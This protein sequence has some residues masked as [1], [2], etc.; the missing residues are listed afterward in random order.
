MSG[1]YLS[2]QTISSGRLGFV[3]QQPDL[4]HRVQLPDLRYK[5]PSS[6]VGGRDH[7]VY[8]RVHYARLG[9]A[10]AERILVCAG[11][12]MAWGMATL[13]SSRW[14]KEFDAWV[15]VAYQ[16]LIEA[17]FCSSQV[18]AGATA[19]CMGFVSDRQGALCSGL[20]DPDELDC[21]IR[22]VVLCGAIAIPIK[23]TCI[24]SSFPCLV[25]YPDGLY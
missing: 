15:M 11:C 24:C 25:Y 5:V 16:M 6:S 22:H 17:S 23:L 3:L 2:M 20:D 12:G 10:D 13:L 9:D 19:F 21:P 7:R 18:R 4:V 1:I 14:G 8:R